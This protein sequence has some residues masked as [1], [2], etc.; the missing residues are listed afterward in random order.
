MNPQE[1]IGEK[2]KF[3][4][5]HLVKFAE[6]MESEC[7]KDLLQYLQSC[8]PVLGW[9]EKGKEQTEYM[10]AVAA[11]HELCIKKMKELMTVVRRAEEIVPDYGVHES[12]NPTVPKSL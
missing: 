6:F 9:Y 8:R 4:K 1:N 7:G 2:E 10:T 11:G 3:Q 5:K 12:Q